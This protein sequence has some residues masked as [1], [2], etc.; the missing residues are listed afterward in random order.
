M[1]GKVLIP[2]VHAVGMHHYGARQLE[3]GA[4]YRLIAEEDNAHDKNA[5]AIHEYSSQRKRA[6][7]TR[8][9]A[10]RLQPLMFH[11]T[12]AVI[13]VNAPSVVVKYEK[14]P[15]HDC[16]VILQF[17]EKNKQLIL[18]HLHGHNVHFNA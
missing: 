12:T 5:I 9:W 8:E 17:T 3:V 15:Q 14:G 16:V 18:H 11:T 2:N 10:K 7:L 4:L 6:Y 13:K 1:V